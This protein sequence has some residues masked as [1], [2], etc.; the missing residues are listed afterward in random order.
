MKGIKE[1][2]ISN[3]AVL[4]LSGKDRLTL[5]PFR[6]DG[7][8]SLNPPG[9]PG[10]LKV[11]LVQVRFAS[12]NFF[13]ETLSWSAD[14]LFECAA[15]QDKLH[16]IIPRAAKLTHA[17]FDFY[18]SDSIEPRS[19]IL[20]PPDTL[21]LTQTADLEIVQRWASLHRFLFQVESRNEADE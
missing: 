21:E 15:F 12:P 11:V 2:A 5:D 17:I 1:P 20:R 8:D 9:I 7:R 18:F 13:H 3:L 19:V 6:S 10:L 4:T 14:D 16:Q